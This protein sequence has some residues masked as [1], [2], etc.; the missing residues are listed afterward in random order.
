VISVPAMAVFNCWLS[1]FY[2]WN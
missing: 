2:R 1:L